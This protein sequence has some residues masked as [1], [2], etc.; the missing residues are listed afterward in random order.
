MSTDLVLNEEKEK[1][2]GKKEKTNLIKILH[3]IIPL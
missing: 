3:S 2:H 1:G